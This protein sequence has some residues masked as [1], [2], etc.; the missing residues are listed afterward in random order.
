MRFFHSNMF[1]EAFLC[2]HKGFVI[3]WQKNISAKA[4]CKMFMKLTTGVNFIYI[5]C[6]TFG[7]KVFCQAFLYL[8][9]GFVIFWQKNIGTKAACKNVDE[10]D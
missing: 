8:L 10:I 3:F 9:L 5:L 2:L 4:A 6:S 1:W 7:T